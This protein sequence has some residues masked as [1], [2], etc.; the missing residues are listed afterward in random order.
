MELNLIITHHLQ[1]QLSH[2]SSLQ[3]CHPVSGQRHFVPNLQQEGNCGSSHLL[4]DLVCNFIF[5]RSILKAGLGVGD[6]QHLALIAFL[7][8]TLTSHWDKALENEDL[9][10]SQEY[11]VSA[12]IV[13]YKLN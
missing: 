10:K 13:L 4:L 11:F 9:S 5:R 7:R 12:L 6:K 3:A 8:H 2:R 1:N